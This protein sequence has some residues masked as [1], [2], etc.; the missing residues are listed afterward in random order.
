MNPLIDKKLPQIID[1]CDKYHVKVLALFGSI[2]GNKFDSKNSDLD[3]V[4]EFFPMVPVQHADS[5]FG[6]IEDLQNLFELEIDLVEYPSIRNP[7]FLEVIEKN[8]VVIYEAA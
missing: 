8:R 4:V 7:F 5:Y 1:L 6:L 2:T 3:L